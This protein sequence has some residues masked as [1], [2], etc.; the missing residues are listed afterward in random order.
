LKDIVLLEN[1]IAEYDWGSYTLIA[2]L[3]GEPR[4]PRLQAELWMGAHEP[5]SSHALLHDGKTS[6]IDL[7]ARQPRS[8]LGRRVSERFGGEFPYLF[9][10]LAAERPLSIQAHPDARTARAGFERENRAGLPLNGDERT[11]VDAHHKPE[12]LCA[13]TPFSTLYGFRPAAE[14]RTAL[15]RLGAGPLAAELTEAVPVRDAGDDAAWLAAFVGGLLRLGEKRA[16][17]AARDIA[18]AA[19]ALA[20][21]DPVFALIAR[22]HDEYPGDRGVFA[23]TFLQ[24]VELEPGEAI[25]LEAGVLHSYLGGMGVELMANSDN[26]L[27]GGLTQKRVDVAELMSVL[28]FESRSPRVLRPVR[29]P[30]GVEVYETPADEFELSRIRVDGEP[31]YP[32]ESSVE[33]GVEIL[34]CTE[35]RVVVTPLGA[36]KGIQLKSGASCL[37]AADVGPYRVEGGGTVFRASVPG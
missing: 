14:V 27:R 29:R 28:E 6:L 3:R 18:G 23:P 17:K 35:G 20:Q 22:L 31:I 34:I 5:Y 21:E 7:T 25:Y 32:V 30:S 36:S 10:V 33:R 13:L 24:W 8:V 4:S 9:K 12:I 2:G 37:V 11:Y 19:S 26:V 15:D 16:E 1:A